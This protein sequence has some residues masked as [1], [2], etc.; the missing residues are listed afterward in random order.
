MPLF[1]SWLQCMQLTA[2]LLEG[3][4]PVVQVRRHERREGAPQ[5]G[6]HRRTA[7]G[8]GNVIVVWRRRLEA[9]VAV[10]AGLRVL[11]AWFLVRR[12]AAAAVRV[13]PAALRDL[14]AVDASHDL[15]GHHVLPRCSCSAVRCSWIC[16]MS[17]QASCAWLGQPEES[18]HGSCSV[19]LCSC[20]HRMSHLSRQAVHV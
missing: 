16:R 5:V 8:G 7:G 1:S 13:R 14:R 11:A 19:V 4:P 6:R 20:T 18:D 15:I 10:C 9:W 2:H 17:Q 12:R 3:R